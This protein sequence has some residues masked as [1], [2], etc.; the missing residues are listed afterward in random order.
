MNWEAIGAIG[1]MGGA[2]GVIATLLYLAHQ[3]RESTI[4]TRL[5]SCEVV[6]DG[7][8]ANIRALTEE[9][10]A[11]LFIR[12]TSGAD[13]L[14]DADSLRFNSMMVGFVLGYQKA[15]EAYRHDVLDDEMFTAFEAD[16][17]D[18]LLNPAIREWWRENQRRYTPRV[19][20]R[21]NAR[22][23]DDTG[24]RAPLLEGIVKRR[25]L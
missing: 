8:Q 9:S 14:S 2:L 22:L 5:H 4:A 6:L 7:Y 13:D 10:L 3:I 18:F 25:E 19:R 21:L 20:D 12:V 11:E 1:E 16:M 24:A 23:E 17:V 15:F